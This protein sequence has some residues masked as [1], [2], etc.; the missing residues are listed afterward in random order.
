MTLW[1]L[2][3]CLSELA[4]YYPDTWVGALDPDRSTAAVT[5]EHGLD[6]ALERAPELIAGALHGPSLEIARRQFREQQLQEA[7]DGQDNDQQTTVVEENAPEGSDRRVMA[8]RPELPQARRLS[9]TFRDLAGE[10]RG[11]GASAPA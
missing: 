4:R 9:R 6:I 5:L 2:L 8:S 3:F 11:L 10:A 1:A 7:A